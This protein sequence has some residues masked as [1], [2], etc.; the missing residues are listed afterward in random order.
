MLA[1]TIVQNQGGA[2]VSSSVRRNASSCFRG[3]MVPVRCFCDEMRTLLSMHW[4]LRRLGQSAAPSLSPSLHLFS[5]SAESVK[6]C[7]FVCL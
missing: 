7:L 4:Q 6:L 5:A 2:I 1:V 3:T